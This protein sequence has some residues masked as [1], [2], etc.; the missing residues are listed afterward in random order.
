MITLPILVINDL[1][2]HAHTLYSSLL[3]ALL[4]S[5]T[6]K[7]KQQLANEMYAFFIRKIANIRAVGHQR[8]LICCEW[9]NSLYI[10]RTKEVSVSLR[11]LEPV[12]FT[13]VLVMFLNRVFS[14]E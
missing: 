11:W 8:L 10:S 13:C 14:Q 7:D 6:R 3:Q 5:G 12:L 1:S 9:S 2:T 4:F